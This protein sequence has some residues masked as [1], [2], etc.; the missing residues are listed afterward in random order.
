VVVLGAAALIATVSM[1][2]LLRRFRATSEEQVR[3]DVLGDGASALG[4]QNPSSPQPA[5]LPHDGAPG[6]PGAAADPEVW[7]CER[8]NFRRPGT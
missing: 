2:R 8:D 3:R 4:A 6:P 1:V 5:Q 7:F